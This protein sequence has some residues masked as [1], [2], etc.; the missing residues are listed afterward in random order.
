MPI[1]APINACE[2]LEG[3]PAPGEEVPGDSAEQHSDEHRHRDA[4]RGGYEASN[5]IRDFRMEDLRRYDRAD[6]IEYGG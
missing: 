6:K 3:S 4:A 5:S 2:E 1:S